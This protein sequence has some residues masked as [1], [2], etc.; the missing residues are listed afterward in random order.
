[1][2]EPVALQQV[3]W[4]LVERLIERLHKD[5]GARGL[6]ALGRYLGAQPRSQARLNLDAD[7]A[8]L[9]LAQRIALEEQVTRFGR[10]LNSQQRL[11]QARGL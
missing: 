4:M 11:D 10:L 5:D 1:M 2:P 8:G 7:E 9:S 3:R 6:S